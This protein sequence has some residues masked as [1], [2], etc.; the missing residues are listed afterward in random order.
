MANEVA[1][2]GPSMVTHQGMVRQDNQDTGLVMGPIENAWDA[3]LVVADGMGGHASGREASTTA[4]NT[5]VQRLVAERE[6]WGDASEPVLESISRGFADANMAVKQVVHESDAGAPPGTTLTCALLRDGRCFVG[7]VGDSRAYLVAPDEIV[8]LTD[9]QTWVAEQ[10]RRGLM[11]PDEA[12]RSPYRSQLLQALGTRNEVVPSISAHD[13]AVGDALLLCTDGLSG[14]L[15]ANEILEAIAATPELQTALHA[16]LQRAL[17]RGGEDN[18]TIAAA[19]ARSG[20]RLGRPALP[21]TAADERHATRPIP[22]PRSA[23]GRQLI[24]HSRAI[25]LLLLGG[26]ALTLALAVTLW[27]GATQPQSASTM[28]TR[29]E[30]PRVATSASGARSD[31]GAMPGS[32]VDVPRPIDTFDREQTVAL[33]IRL[34]LK[35][36]DLVIEPLDSGVRLNAKGLT[37]SEDELKSTGALVRYRFKSKRDRDAVMDGSAAL[38]FRSEGYEV[39]WD[40]ASARSVSLDA[41]REYVV[42]FV[43]ATRDIGLFS[44]TC[45]FADASEAGPADHRQTQERQRR[46]NGASVFRRL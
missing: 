46:T 11:T 14:H 43:Q 37:S 16:L 34:P 15:T 2:Y 10:V 25:G 17:G 36:G 21:S 45:T 28:D 7:H 8:Q 19:R 12:L 38:L 23:T 26:A 3:L 44:L 35:G 24:P 5:L 42:R 4:A 32:P 22:I 39:R 1:D 18:I 13:L 40:F 20:R 29:G 33:S 27:Q 41:G 31:D 30:P 9:D 6:R